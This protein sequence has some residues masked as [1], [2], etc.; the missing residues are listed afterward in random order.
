MNKIKNFV[1]ACFSKL[2]ILSI[3]TAAIVA[4]GLVFLFVFGYPT[5]ATNNDVTTLTVRVNQYAYTQHLEEIEDVAENFFATKGLKYEYDLNAEM[6]GD[7]SEIVYVFDKDTAISETVIDELQAAF[8]ALTANESEHVLAGSIVN[9]SSNSERALDRLPGDVLVRLVIAA[10]A[11][12]VL[13]CLYVALRHHYV[14]GLTLFVSLSVGVALTSALVLITRMPITGNL[15]Y[16][17]FFNL[18]FT[19]V[20]TMF[21]L[22]KVRKAQKDDK[23]VDAETLIK[24]NV[25]VE[26]V[27]VFAAANVVAL[28]LFG[29]IATSAVRWFAAISLLSVVAGV[30]ASLFLAPAL[31]MFVKK[32][33]DA[34]DAERARYDYKRS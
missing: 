22:N 25:A 21:T 4:L 30:F 26:Q 33:S 18:L 34:K 27:L 8:N 2:N 6:Y 1:T 10:G 28:V 32:Y 14:S 17:L 20:C 12:A 24:S 23:K 15:L 31:Y 7:E 13:A 16:T 5:N 29:A 9:V 11:F 3:V 19:A